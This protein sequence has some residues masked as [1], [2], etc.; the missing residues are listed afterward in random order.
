MLNGAEIGVIIVGYRNPDDL[1]ICL[2][3]L[4]A[5]SATPS[6]TV[7]ICENGGPAAF[8]D[9]VTRL[10][11]AGAPCE[12]PVDEPPG[13][14]SG[15]ARLRQLRLS[16]GHQIVLA[17]EAPENLGFAGGVNAWLRPL[18]AATD[19]SGVWILN[20]DTIPDRDALAELVAYAAARGKG[21]V[22]S[23]AMYVD[24][25]DV[26]R[27]RGLTWRKL[28][29]SVLGVDIYA[30]A[31]LAP[32]PDELEARIDAPSGCS[33][34][35]TRECLTKIGLMEES[36][37]LYYEDLDWGL[38]AKACCGVGYAYR[39]VV[40]HVGGSTIGT[41]RARSKASR[42]SVYLDFRNRMNFVRRNYPGWW[43]WTAIM[44]LA[45]SARF[46]LSGAGGNFISALSGLRA[47]LMGETGRPKWLE[48]PG[49]SLS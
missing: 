9:L 23:R 14:T 35:V 24:R 12:G 18:Q 10:S 20:P 17:G 34:Y 33:F 29:A 25:P 43:A 47:G 5:A 30:P 41:A 48:Q 49:P 11:A 45:H 8:D 21:M 15:F 4:S 7:L 46:L 28:A 26:V 2:Q 22:G 32:D 27:T 40:P 36:Y 1:A 31:S 16:G 6:F 37:F 44:A 42:L 13:P 19:W 39:S 38:R 3:A